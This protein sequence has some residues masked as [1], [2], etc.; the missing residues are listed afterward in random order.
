MQRRVV[1]SATDSPLVHRTQ[2]GSTS[3]KSSTATTTAAC[4]SACCSAC[5]R[6]CGSACSRACSSACSSAC[7]HQRRCC[8]YRHGGGGVLLR[9]VDPTKGCHHT[10][11]QSSVLRSAGVVGGVE[12]QHMKGAVDSQRFYC[13]SGGR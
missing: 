3:S 12:A 2:V 6:R 10:P 5:R 7:K 4:R 13:A 11:V 9:A 1:Q 8:D